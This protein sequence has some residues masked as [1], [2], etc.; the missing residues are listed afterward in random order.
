MLTHNEILV[1]ASS[2]HVAAVCLPYCA[3][4]EKDFAWYAPLA[5]LTAAIAGMQHANEGI[6]LPVVLYHVEDK[7]MGTSTVGQCEYVAQG[8]AEC[9][10]VALKAIEELQKNDML[11]A[12]DWMDWH[13]HMRAEATKRENLEYQVRS[14]FG[15]ELNEPLTTQQP[16]IARAR[17]AAA[18]QEA[19][20]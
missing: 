7:S 17:A 14:Q 19:I 13:H 15:I 16:A 12:C 4:A 18:S 2:E 6:D 9:L 10:E 5:R 8:K 3:A 11:K 20:R 1:A